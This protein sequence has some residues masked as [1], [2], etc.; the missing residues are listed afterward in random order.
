[1]FDAF[2]YL[3]IAPVSRTFSIAAGRIGITL[4]K[5]RRPRSRGSTKGFRLD[6]LA[7]LDRF[8]HRISKL[9]AG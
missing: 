9:E 1:M 2:D 4:V 5:Y 3:I 7:E 6:C 8:R